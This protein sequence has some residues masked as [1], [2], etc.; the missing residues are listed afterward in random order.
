[1]SQATIYRLAQAGQI[2]CGK[3]G[4]A[5]RFHKDAI[6]LWISGDQDGS[7]KITTNRDSLE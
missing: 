2:P 6:N 7:T 4:R 5:W 1:M 3:V